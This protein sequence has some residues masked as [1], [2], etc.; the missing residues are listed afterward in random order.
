MRSLKDL[1]FIDIMSGP[2]GPISCEL[3]FN[4]FLVARVHHE[5]DH[6]NETFFISLAQR[7]I[8][9]RAHDFGALPDEEVEKPR[10]A[11]RRR[12]RHARKAAV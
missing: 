12:R 10:A 11:L 5:A 8:E 9:V 3:I 1:G 7:T 4:P 2:N 6:V